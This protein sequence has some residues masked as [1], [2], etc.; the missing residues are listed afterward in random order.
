MTATTAPA[1]TRPRRRWPRR[2]LRGFLLLVASIVVALG[3][4]YWWI[5]KDLPSLDALAQPAAQSTRIFDRDGRLLYQ[6]GAAGAQRVVVP[7]VQIPPALQ[8]ATIAAEDADFYNN[9]G[10]DLGALVRALWLNLSSGEVVSGGS[11]ITQQLARTVLLTDQERGE[12]SYL[13]KAREVILAQRITDRYSKDEVLALYLNYVY[14]GNLAYGVEAAAQAYFGKPARDLDLAECALLAGLPQSPST[15]NPATTPDAARARQRIVLDLIVKRGY[16]TAAQADAAAKEDLSYAATR[17]P[18]Q[19][20]HFVLYVRDLLVA[21]YGR[22]MVEQGG[23]KVVTTLSLPLQERAQEV[24]RDHLATLK[25]RNVTNAAVVVIEPHSGQ[26]LTMLGSVDY[27]N[28]KIDGE[29]NVA[30]APR[31]PGSSIKPLVYAA[32]LKAG[33]SPATILPDIKTTYPDNDGSLYMPRNYD[34]QWHGPTIMRRALANSYNVASVALLDRVGV[35]DAAKVANDLGLTTLDPDRLGLSLTLG[36]GEVR[37]LDLTNAFV[38]LRNGGN[39]AEPSAI[40]RVETAD[41]KLL[42][43]LQPPSYTPAL[44]ANGPQVAY[45]ITAMLADDAARIPA[46]GQSNVLDLR[47]PAAVKTGTT[48]NYRDNWTLGYTTD[49]VV[50]VWVGNSN[51]SAMRDSSG[52]TGAAPI[53]HDVILSAS[54]GQPIRDFTAPLGLKR[55]EVCAL[56]GLLPTQWC[57]ERVSEWFISGTEPKLTDNFYQAVKVDRRNNLR[58]TRRTPAS[59]VVEKIFIQLPPEYSDWARE[60][61]I[62]RL[63]TA[64]SPLGAST[65]AALQVIVSPRDGEYVGGVVQVRGK[66]PPGA[67]DVRLTAGRAGAD[68]AGD[69]LPLASSDG[70]LASWDTRGLSGQLAL[71]LSYRMDGETL[72]EVVTVAVDSI[73]PRAGILYPGDGAE[74]SIAANAGLP[75]PFTADAADNYAVNR[76]LFYADGQPVG[77]VAGEGPYTIQLNL[78][79]LGAGEHT[80]AA[81]VIDRAGN[82]TTARSIKITLK[83]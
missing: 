60:Q 34:G 54:E 26:I 30:L 72:T 2:L 57:G 9:P 5:A 58:A 73:P 63:P 28:P 41:G 69:P 18:I 82:Q 20:P 37:L 11:T 33:I 16:I 74:F 68:E 45:Q 22:E 35:G 53:W 56:S 75:E 64:D 23:L 50:G 66:L 4:A 52:V 79:Q 42:D 7:L 71:R 13:R 29:V 31:Q 81:T 32:A 40:L 47:R 39:Y 67:T 17:Y 6:I 21:K 70:V 80:L 44:G 48:T 24:A 38:A 27:F 15:Y 59:E 14:Y 12:R 65:D 61:N 76:V 3:T 49:Y 10:Y 78:A 25:Q 8:Q 77:Q 62:A 83:P 55:V 43:E 19:A 36:G 51:N 46:F 1:T